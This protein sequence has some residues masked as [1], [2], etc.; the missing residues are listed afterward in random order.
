[1][2]A[3]TKAASTKVKDSFCSYLTGQEKPDGERESKRE[4]KPLRIIFD[5]QNI[6]MYLNFHVN[7][8]P[9]YFQG[10]N[11]TFLKVNVA[12]FRLHLPPGES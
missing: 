1:M 12:M 5:R 6:V 8:N 3:S 7:K 10:I 11:Y 2:T 9:Y 4:C